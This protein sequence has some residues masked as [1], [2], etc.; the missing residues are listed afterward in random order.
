MPLLSVSSI[1]SGPLVSLQSHKGS[2]IA[3]NSFSPRDKSSLTPA[4]SGFAIYALHTA[5]LKSCL[6]LQVSLLLGGRDG[7][8]QDTPLELFKGGLNPVHAVPNLMRTQASSARSPAVDPIIQ[9]RHG[10]HPIPH[11][12]LSRQWSWHFLRRLSWLDS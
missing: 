11:S 4:T 6:L 5:L 1:R 9:G 12:A 3:T 8:I 10:V 2:R 7:W